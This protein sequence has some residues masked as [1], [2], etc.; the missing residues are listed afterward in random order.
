MNATVARMLFFIVCLSLAILLLTHAISPVT[1]G[2]CFALALLAF[3]VTSR[4]S[5]KS[6]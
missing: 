6:R 5:R 4:G 2:A 3:G 1:S